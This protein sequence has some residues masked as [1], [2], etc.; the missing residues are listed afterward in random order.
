[1]T[2]GG[3]CGTLLCVLGRKRRR[4]QDFFKETA[5]A[6]MAAE[7]QRPWFLGDDEDP[8]L[9]IEAG[10]SAWTGLPEGDG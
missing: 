4:D 10:R 3:R 5:R 7:E 8:V 1:L 2:G 9:D 6:R